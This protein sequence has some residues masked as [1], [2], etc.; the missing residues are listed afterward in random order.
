MRIYG[1]LW[2][3]YVFFMVF[4]G[5]SMVFLRI[6]MVDLW[7]LGA[8]TNFYGY[9]AYSTAL[10]HVPGEVNRLMATSSTPRKYPDFRFTH[11]YAR[12]RKFT[13]ITV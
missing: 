12:L 2:F 4:Y 6:F 1:Y 5:F 13:P 10:G 3:V 8:V 9:S 7:S 11:K